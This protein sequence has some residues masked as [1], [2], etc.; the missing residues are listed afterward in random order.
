MNRNERLRL[1]LSGCGCSALLIAIL[2]IGLFVWFPTVHRT[3]PGI[4]G[5]QTQVAFSIPGSNR[6]V[7]TPTLMEAHV[8]PAAV[9]AP[10]VNLQSGTPAPDPISSGYL[11]QLYNTVSPGV[12]SIY[13]TIN[14]QGQTGEAAGS[15]FIFDQSG[16][17]VTNNHVVENANLVVVRFQDGSEAEGQIVGTDPYSD[18]AVVKVK[19]LPDTAQ[20]LPL[21]DSDTVRTGEWAVAI[22]NPFG[23]NSSMSIGIISAVGRTIPSLAA[24][25]SIPMAIQTDAAINPGNSGGPLLNLQ[26]QVI[27]VNAQIAA[28]SGGA[29]AGVGFSIPANIVRRVIPT[30]ISQGAFQWSWLG[31]EGTDMNMFIAQANHLSQQ[32]GAYIVQVV[33]GGP[34]DQAGLQG[35]DTTVTVQGMDVPAGGDVITAID[36]TPIETY[37]DLMALM[38]QR[39][40]GTN[41]EL[42]ILRDGKQQAVTVT[43]GPRPSSG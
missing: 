31:I 40:P 20:V 4:S 19:Q 13:V 3:A 17:I 10:L 27:G 43:L 24:S 32:R 16:D 5:N 36:G 33:P 28:G 26:G 11:N 14:N 37:T 8:T 1:F 39:D 7:A 38:A 2:V 42:T 23:L 30:L 21:G 29:N 12:V 41:V 22:G 15:G 25:F 35:G 18:L 6:L 9:G 34:A